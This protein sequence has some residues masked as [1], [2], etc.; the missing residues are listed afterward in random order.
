MHASLPGFRVC[1]LR[2][3]RRIV[4]VALLCVASAS[5]LAQT[6]NTNY[7]NDYP[8]VDR[9]KA[10][11]KGSDPTDTLARQVAVFTYLSTQIDRIKLNRDY[12]G[13]YTPDETRVMT[14]LQR[15]P[16]IRSRRTTPNPT[17]PPRRRP[18]SVSTANYEMDPTFRKDWTKRLI[19][20]QGQHAYKGAQADLAANQQRHYNQEMQTY[21]DAKKQ[22]EAAAKNPAGLSN[23]PTAVATRR[24]LELG[25]D[26]TACMGKSFLG[27]LMGMV[28]LDTNT[29]TGPTHSG[30]V[31]SGRYHNPSTLASISFG[32]DT[33]AIQ[34]CGKLVADG[35]AYTIH[36]SPSSLDIVI[37]NEPRPIQLSMRPD[38]ALTG[39]GPVDVKGRIIIGYHT[40]TTQ[41]YLNGQRR[42]RR[43]LQRPLHHHDPGPRLRPQDR[44]LHH[45][46][47]RPAAA[48]PTRLRLEWRGRR[49][50]RSP[51][52]HDG[53]RSPALRTRPPHVRQIRRPLRPPPRLRW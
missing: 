39:P 20:P 44:A 10:E 15:S 36:K 1:F 27:G 28:G 24:C 47:P 49:H 34:D 48:K 23:D 14:R 52:R 16:P 26:T 3:P 18:S 8:S 50:D 37:E 46:L 21:N 5:V 33:A 25:G 7:T 40:V 11:I 9:V 32:D 22:Q 4:V 43:Q 19:G 6:A 35:H 29:L 51:H 12:R 53:Q 41:A 45:R 30:V 31:L 17:P 2:R 42:L 13:P 38:G